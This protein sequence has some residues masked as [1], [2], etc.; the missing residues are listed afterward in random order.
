M[1]LFRNDNQNEQACKIILDKME[2]E[3]LDLKTVIENL[4]C[5]IKMK[6]EQLSKYK[7]EIEKEKTKTIYSN[8]QKIENKKLKEEIEERK[9]KEV[10]KD[11]ENRTET[12]RLTN[13]FK[14]TLKSV[15][16]LLQEERDRN[17]DIKRE[18]EKMETDNTNDNKNETKETNIYE[19]KSCNFTSIWMNQL[20][21]HKKK[22]NK[23]KKPK[24]K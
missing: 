24:N 9:V 3:N 11:E 22:C 13:E 12:E 10:E 16:K 5:E 14:V 20:R 4:K 15:K 17:D 21:D 1:T 23:T 2:Q 18:Q 7:K 19:C 6:N 8:L